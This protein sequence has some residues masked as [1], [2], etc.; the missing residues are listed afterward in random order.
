MKQIVEINCFNKYKNIKEQLST[1]H[2]EI[3]FSKLIDSNLKP[4]SNIW[5][6]HK[7]RNVLK[8]E[9]VATLLN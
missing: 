5:L 8:S 4:N 7:L 6:Q 1:Y 2:I 3:K 9:R